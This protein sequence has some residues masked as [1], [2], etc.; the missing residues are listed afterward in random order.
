[1]IDW[2]FRGENNDVMWKPYG[3]SSETGHLI[4][5]D[6][7]GMDLTYLTWRNKDR[8]H[9]LF[10]PVEFHIHRERESTD[11]VATGKG[12]QIPTRDLGTASLGRSEQ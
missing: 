7:S 9:T 12:C 5:D 1:M 10:G 6:K 8:Y 11:M 4:S 2:G 3:P